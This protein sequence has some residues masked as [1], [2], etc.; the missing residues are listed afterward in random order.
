MSEAGRTV[1][2]AIHSANEDARNNIHG[3]MLSGGALTP[4]CRLP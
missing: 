4:R 2:N 3:R 1:D